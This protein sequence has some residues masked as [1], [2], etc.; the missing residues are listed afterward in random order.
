MAVFSLKKAEMPPF[1]VKTICWKCL[2][3]LYECGFIYDKLYRFTSMYYFHIITLLR[4]L[5]L[6]L[7]TAKAWF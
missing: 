5:P 2:R 6:L 4:C 3:G 1:F 7:P